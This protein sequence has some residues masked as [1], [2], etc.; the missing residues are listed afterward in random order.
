MQKIVDSDASFYLWFDKGL[1]F[2]HEFFVDALIGN[3][4]RVVTL[5][6]RDT[7]TTDSRLMSKHES[8]IIAIEMAISALFA[9]EAVDKT[10]RKERKSAQLREFINLPFRS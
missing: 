8:E 1:D 6:S 10:E 9:V 2:G 4:P 7:Q 5:R 3:L